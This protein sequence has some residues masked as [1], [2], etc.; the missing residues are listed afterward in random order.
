M[1]SLGQKIKHLRLQKRM[2]QIELAKQLCTPSMISQ[3]ESDRARPS[4]KILYGLADR[5]EVPLEHL[6]TDVDLNQEFISTYK[7]A[8]AMVSAQDYTAAIPFLERLK[9]TTQAQ[10]P[11]TDILFDLAEC[12]IHT[13]RHADADNILSHILE[14]AFLK[15]DSHLS[16]RV[17]S[18]LGRLELNNKRYQLAA[19][20]WHKAY[21]ESNKM[22]EP[23]IYLQARIL[24]DLGTA[25]F[26][27]GKLHDALDYYGR[28]S[29]LYDKMD[30][31]QEMGNVYLNLGISYHK[32]NDL[33]K[34]AEY[35]EKAVHIYES[36]NNIVMT[37]KLQATCAV[38]YG[39]SGREAEAISMLQG[40]VTN[41]LTL[42][43]QEEAGMTSVELATLLLQ[44]N[45]LHAAEEACYQAR[46]LLPELHIYQARVHRL[47]GR[48]AVQNGHREEAI[49]RFQKSADRFKHTDELGEWG[50]TMSE[51]AELY[52]NEGDL[53]TAVGV[54]QEIRGYTRQAMLK[55]GIAL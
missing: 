18:S 17:Y 20:H 28:S 52:K 3:I 5:L 31:L 39:Q 44:Q 49:R 33:E 19:Y 7:M 1:Y 50:D 48:I 36:L 38:L 53:K 47:Y 15:N 45:D 24:Y 46:K 10:I 54:M 30:S 6:L 55:R 40:A 9:D 16:A 35:S 4:Y 51:L 34:A 26:K 12:Y 22:E 43:K 21:D 11:E 41:L 37:V 29:A 32:L 2:T 13:H 27:S 25:Y 42:G 8:K 23:D 14:M